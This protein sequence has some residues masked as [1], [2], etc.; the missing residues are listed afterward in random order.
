MVTISSN[1]TSKWSS[2][3]NGILNIRNNKNIS[4][5]SNWKILCILPLNS[6][7]TWCDNLEIN[8]ISEL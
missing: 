2:G 7:I 3:Y 1:I 5:N 8:I 4:Y 6:T